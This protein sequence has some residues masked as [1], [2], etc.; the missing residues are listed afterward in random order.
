M[1]R[2]DMYGTKRYDRDR[3]SITMFKD[4]ELYT[5]MQ[6]LSRGERALLDFILKE[7]DDGLNTI[8]LNGDVMQRVID[9]TGL[10]K[11]TIDVFT[12]K[13]KKEGFI[14]K[15]LLAYEYVVDPRLAIAGNEV[16]VYRNVAKIEEQL[17][18]KANK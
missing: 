5:H 18:L 15:A 4:T 14:S 2:N 6:I 7:M 16:E 1:G 3:R 13:L 11:G 8:I 17:K 9:S 12:S 10:T